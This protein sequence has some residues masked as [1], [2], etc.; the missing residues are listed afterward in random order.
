MCSRRLHRGRPV[1][2][3]GRGGV[4]SRQSAA[5]PGPSPPARGGGRS[6]RRARACGIR[7]APANRPHAGRSWPP[8]Q[9]WPARDPVADSPRAR[10]RAGCPAFHA[11]QRAGED[12]TD[13]PAPGSA[14]PAPTGGCAP[15][16]SRLPP[17]LTWPSISH[18]TPVPCRG[19]H[20]PRSARAA[21]CSPPSC[22]RRWAGPAAARR[23]LRPP[24]RWR[25]PGRAGGAAQRVAGDAGAG[26]LRT[27]L[28]APARRAGKRR[29]PPSAALPP[30]AE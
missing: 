23:D 6:M 3:R 4:R 10:F 20:R 22:R 21:P 9:R 12:G 19:P 24:P 30:I 27:V 16:R 5:G 11:P 15:R 7:W 2:H 18:R 1:R 26:D 29:R 28:S 13:R 8:I 17:R 14:A 25:Q